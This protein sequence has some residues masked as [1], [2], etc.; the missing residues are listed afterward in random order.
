[1]EHCGM[2]LLDLQKAF[3]TVAHQIILHKGPSWV[4]KFLELS[5]HFPEIS[6]ECFP[7]SG[8]NKAGNPECSKQ[9]FGK[10]R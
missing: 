3:D 2:V 5:I 6:F 1:M 9:D 4:V 8:G 10:T 7:E